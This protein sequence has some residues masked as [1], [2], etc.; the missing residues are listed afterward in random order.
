[1]FVGR[2]F[3]HKGPNVVIYP[4]FILFSIGFLLLSFTNSVFLLLLSGVFVGLGYGILVPSFQ[5]LAVQSADKMRS[6]HATATFCTLF[7]SGI[8]IGSFI[9]G[10]VVTYFSYKNLYFFNAFF[11]LIPFILY[12]GVLYIRNVK[13]RRERPS[14]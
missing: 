2:L 1:L 3:D 11:I 5:T 8:A 7:D 6:G 14:N 13:A 10:I 9:L 12:S 4:A